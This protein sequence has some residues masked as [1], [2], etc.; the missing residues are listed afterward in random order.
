MSRAGEPYDNAKSER[1]MSILNEEDVN[2]KAYASIDE[3]RT[4]IGALLENVL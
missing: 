4:D 1:F 2:G 3:V